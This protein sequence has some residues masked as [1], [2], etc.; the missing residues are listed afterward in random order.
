MNQLT[1]IQAEEARGLELARV[2]SICHA[3]LETQG[4][5]T[6][7]SVP[8]TTADILGAWKS[9]P[10]IQAYLTQDHLFNS[11]P[12]RLEAFIHVAC[13][14]LGYPYLTVDVLVP[15]IR[16]TIKRYPKLL[17]YAVTSDHEPTDPV[18]FT[19]GFLI[20]QIQLVAYT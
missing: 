9:F 18:D 12:D 16:E 15:L 20:H 17:S 11:E 3:I 14:K 2:Y 6:R 13:D 8:V 4:W 1:N 7:Y 10:S 5:K 19:L